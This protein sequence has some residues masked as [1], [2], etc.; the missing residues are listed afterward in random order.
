[1]CI[2]QEQCLLK[3]DSSEK[4]VFYDS[5]DMILLSS[6]IKAQ[7]ISVEKN[8]KTPIPGTNTIPSDHDGYF[9]KFEAE[10]E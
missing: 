3:N 9:I 1:M 6:N 2:K 5:I 8:F 10:L 4:D 7:M